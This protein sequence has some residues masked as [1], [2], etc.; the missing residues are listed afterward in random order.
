LIRS[1]TDH[2]DRDYPADSQQYVVS[3]F[4]GRPQQVPILPA[5]E[6]SPICRMGVMFGKAVAEI[7]WQALIQ[8]N[9]HAIIESRDSF[10]SSSD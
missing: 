7:D 1:G 4:F 6:S 8:Q 9:L 2:D 3:G 10:A 5:F